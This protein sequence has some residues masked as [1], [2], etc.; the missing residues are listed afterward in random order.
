MKKILVIGSFM[1]DLVVQ[2]DR[3]TQEGETIFGTSFNQFTGGKGANQAVA[4][5]KLGGNVEIIGEL[6]KDSFGEDQIASM[7]ENNIKHEH[8]L[9]TDKARSGIGNPQLD[10]AGHNRIVVIPGANMELKPSDLE[11]LKDVIQ[12]SDIIVLQLEV[13][14]ETVYK[15]IEL[16]AQY[17]KLVILNPAPAKEIDEKYASMVD[18]IAPN[19]HEAALLTGIATDTEQGIIDAANSLLDQ[20]Y[21]NVLMTLGENGCYFKNSETD[22][23]ISG[24][25]V[26]PVDTTAAGDSFIGSFAYVLANDHSIEEALRYATASSAIAVTRMGAQPSLPSKLEVDQFLEARASV[27]I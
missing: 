2:S 11:D 27:V 17:K 16:G 26:D 3:F 9:F 7:E 12:E 8:V 20:G 1:T 14:M 4:A 23:K 13:P 22:Y 25:K 15:A 21:K 18:I 19:E 24:F 5:A 6:G 10:K